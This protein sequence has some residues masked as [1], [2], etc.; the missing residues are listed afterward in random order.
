M[1]ELFIGTFGIVG[2]LAVAAFATRYKALKRE[3][4]I[5]KNYQLRTEHP[6]VEISSTHKF[7]DYWISYPQNGRTIY[8]FFESPGEQERAVSERK[9]AG[10]TTMRGKRFD[11]TE[12]M[13][14]N[15]AES[16]KR[17]Y[18]EIPTP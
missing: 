14:W 6:D 3:V 17:P 4:Y 11:A 7:G 15:A 9:A 12:P 18:A 8:E 16:S 5:L 10:K 13:C 1:G 2:V